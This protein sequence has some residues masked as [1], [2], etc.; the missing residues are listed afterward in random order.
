MTVEESTIQTGMMNAVVNLFGEEGKEAETGVGKGA[1]TSES[2]FE[3]RNCAF[4]TSR[5]LSMYFSEVIGE[6]WRERK[7]GM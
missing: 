3:L 4:S 7:K 2:G 1:I 5:A 6:E